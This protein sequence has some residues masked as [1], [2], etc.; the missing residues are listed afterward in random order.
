[1]KPDE[2]VDSNQPDTDQILHYL[3]SAA[4]SIVKGVD[5][6]YSPEGKQTITHIYNWLRSDLMAG[7]FKE[8]EKGY[9][10][11]LRK[12]PDE[13]SELY[14]TMYEHAGLGMDGTYEEFMAKCTDTGMAEG[15]GSTIKRG[16]K[17]IKRGM[18]GWGQLADVPDDDP[19][20]L[21]GAKDSPRQLV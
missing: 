13:A 2:F 19:R 3:T 9:D 21:P 17:N 20:L 7:N 6:M 15:I 4:R 12:Y 1:M 14:D 18:Q 16:I 11:A 10:E 8:F 5:T